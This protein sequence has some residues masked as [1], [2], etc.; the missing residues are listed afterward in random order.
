MKMLKLLPILLIKTYQLTW[1][2]NVIGCHINK[3]INKFLNYS[4]VMCLK[5]E[6]LICKIYIVKSIVVITSLC[7]LLNTQIKSN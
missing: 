4:F 5:V 6:T 2:I 1:Q 7:Q 3:M